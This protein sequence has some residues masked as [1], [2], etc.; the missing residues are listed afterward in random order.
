VLRDLGKR[1]AT[2]VQRSATSRTTQPRIPRISLVTTD[3]AR[4]APQCRGPPNSEEKEQA[5][6][7]M[8]LLSATCTRSDGMPTEWK[9]IGIVY[10]T[11]VPF[12]SGDWAFGNNTIIPSPRQLA[13]ALQ[14][15]P[16]RYRTNISMRK[17]SRRNGVRNLRS[18]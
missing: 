8:L 16:R 2:Q 6:L 17:K 7:T 5:F 14:R 13:A 4:M 15:S 12:A 1:H 11:S 18:L 9:E 10:T 3:D